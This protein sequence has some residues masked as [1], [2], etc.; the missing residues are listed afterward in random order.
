MQSRRIGDWMCVVGDK[1][2]GGYTVQVTR[3][4]M[5]DAERAAYDAKWGGRVP[6]ARQ[7]TSPAG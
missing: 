4:R 5:N 6:A 3:G 7:G 1:V 2:Y